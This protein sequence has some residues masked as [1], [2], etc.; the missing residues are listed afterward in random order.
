[1]SRIIPLQRKILIK[2]LRK[3]GFTGPFP[4][5]RHEYLMK[6]NHK[7]FIPNTHGNKDIGIPIIKEILKQLGIN[8]DDFLNL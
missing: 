2:K 3:L 8:R 4:A 7:I 1:M 6:A 5:T